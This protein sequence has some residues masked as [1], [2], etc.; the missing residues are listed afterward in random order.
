MTE[1]Y[2]HQVPE[3]AELEPHMARLESQGKWERL[4]REIIKGCGANKNDGL[5]HVYRKK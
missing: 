5:F 1:H 2:I 4:R 3:L